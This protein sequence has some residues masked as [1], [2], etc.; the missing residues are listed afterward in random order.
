[1]LY[2]VILY[3]PCN[4]QKSKISENPG[5]FGG[6]KKTRVE[7]LKQWKYGTTQIP[8]NKTSLKRLRNVLCLLGYNSLVYVGFLPL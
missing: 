6:L 5:T 7:N 3:L 2:C 4:N 1:M 8:E